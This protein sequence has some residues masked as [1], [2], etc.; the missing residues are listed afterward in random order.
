[1]NAINSDL[2]R[3]RNQHSDAQFDTQV[4]RQEFPVSN[5][6]IRTQT[7]SQGAR[8]VTRT[9]EDRDVGCNESLLREMLYFDR[10]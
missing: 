2:L 3:N 7:S 1:M 5:S 8:L 10:F 9:S 4:I 6:A